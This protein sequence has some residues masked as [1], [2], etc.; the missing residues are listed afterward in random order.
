MMA[1][2]GI[3][4]ILN[5]PSDIRVQS[6]PS[7]TLLRFLVKQ[8]TTFNMVISSS[9]MSPVVMIHLIKVPLEIYCSWHGLITPRHRRTNSFSVPRDV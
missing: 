2:T 9:Y 8:D 1:F 4:F 3:N 5:C 6:F 7:S